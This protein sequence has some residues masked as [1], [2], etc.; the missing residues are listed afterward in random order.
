[1]LRKS[2]INPRLS[3]HDQLFGVFNHDRAPLDPLGTK[4]TIHKRPKS[5]QAAWALLGKLGWLIGPAVNHCRHF[6]VNVSCTGGDLVSDTTQFLPAKFIMPQT[7]SQDLTLAALDEI[8][9]ATWRLRPQGPCLDCEHCRNTVTEISHMFHTTNSAPRVQQDTQ[10]ARTYRTRSSPR[11]NVAPPPRVARTPISLL[12]CLSETSIC[13]KFDGTLCKGTV[14]RQDAR[15]KLCRV[16]C[17]DGDSKNLTH[18]QI[19]TLLHFQIQVGQDP[20]LAR[21][22]DCLTPR[23]SGRRLGPRTE[24]QHTTGCNDAAMSL[25]PNWFG[26]NTHIK[27]VCKHANS[28]LDKETRKNMEHRQL[29]KDPRVAEA[30]LHA[31]ANKFGHLFQGIGCK[32]GKQRVAGTNACFWIPKSKLPKHEKVTIPRIVCHVK[33]EKEEVNRVR[34]TAQGQNSSH[35]GNAATETAGMTTSK[36]S[37]N[38]V[39]STPEAKFMTMDISNMCLNTHLTDHQCMKF[40]ITMMPEEVILE[41]NL[42][43]LVTKDRWICCQPDTGTPLRTDNSTADRILNNALKQKRSKAIDMRFYWLQDRISSRQSQPC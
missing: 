34:I 41:H 18:A 2:R 24:K 8:S 25:S 5:Q 39:V 38:S 29:T 4:V 10:P 35:I 28:V 37:F 21:Q 7:S 20:T 19:K 12:P 27:Q 6:E 15:R 13:K 33:P 14:I 11:T 26:D 3:A 43:N 36:M 30:W 16:A 22:D 1:M 9:N 31:G 40:R 42:H 17:T 23:Q 32:G